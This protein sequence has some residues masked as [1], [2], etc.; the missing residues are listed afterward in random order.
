LFKFN[1]LRIKNFDLKP[2][3][4]QTGD[5]VIMSSINVSEALENDRQLRG[6]TGLARPEF[7]KLAKAFA[8]FLKNGLP[9]HRR[10]S[11]KNRKR[12]SGGGQKSALGSAEQQL[13]FILFYQ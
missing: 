7:E 9:H 12:K 6:L 8:Q 1:K 3:P 5:K 10:K 13:F 4:Q 2:I 11:R